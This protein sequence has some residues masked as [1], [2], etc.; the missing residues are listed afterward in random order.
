L[1]H[2]IEVLIL[3]MSLTTLWRISNRSRRGAGRLLLTTLLEVLCS[4][5]FGGAAFA[6][7]GCGDAETAQPVQLADAVRQSLS[8][9]P[10]LIVAQQEVVEARSDVRAAVAPFLPTV[11]ASLMD[12]KYVPANGGGPVIVVGNNVLGGPQTKSGYGSLSLTWNVMNSGRDVA[13]LRSAMAG[14]H[15]ASFGLDSQLSDTLSGVLQAYADLYEAE[16]DA[17]NQAGA[18]AVLKEIHARAEERFRNGNG[19][20]VAIG[21][22]RTAELDAEQSLNKACRSVSEKSAALAEAVG[23]RIPAQQRLDATQPLPMPLIDAGDLAARDEIV[24]NTPTVA[25][26]K[27]QVAAATAKFQQ[28]KRAFGPSITFTARRDYLG[29]DPD[30]Y[31]AANHHIVPSDYRLDLGIQQPL[32]PVATE[33]AAVDR[34]RSELRKAQA[35]YDQA[36]LEAETKLRGALSAQR[37]AEASFT[38]ARTSLGE[39]QQVLTLTESLY[40][41]GRTDLD[42]VQHARMDRDKAEAETRTLASK[43]ASAEWAVAKVLH[44]TLFPDVLFGQ[45]HLQVEARRWRDGDENDQPL[46]SHR[47]H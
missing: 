15:V 20:T 22:A 31:G 28:A 42:N 8:A 34:A 19:T 7:S 38:A 12:E 11:T 10:Q 5:G 25:A 30:S 6:N 39:S 27:A 9:Q 37:E 32:F 41:A 14:V 35:G 26:A 13:G 43:R 23:I 44:P 21:Q 36:R 24:E 3:G 1:P 2:T 17:A 46:L 4:V 18:T 45:L 16:V 33:V 40:H 47:F 29:Q